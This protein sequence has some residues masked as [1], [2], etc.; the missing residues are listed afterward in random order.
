MPV[1]LTGSRRV[2]A[3][4]LGRDCVASLCGCGAAAAA[5]CGLATRSPPARAVGKSF[6][7]FS[8]YW[9]QQAQYGD[10]SAA[11]VSELTAQVKEAEE[12]LA[13]LQA[14]RRSLTA[15]LSDPTASLTLPEIKAKLAEV[16]A[17]LAAGKERLTTLQTT[18]TLVTP[19]QRSVALASLERYRKAWASRKAMVAE[20][21]DAMAEGMEKRPRDVLEMLGVDTDESAGVSIKDFSAASAMATGSGG[22]GGGG[23]AGRRG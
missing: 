1:R 10:V 18:T 19:A 4:A 11:R 21:V 9:P 13:E 7:K 14:R 16:R 8:L 2:G 12:R 20:V 5:P 15:S 3:A 17:A 22:S 23:G 6:G